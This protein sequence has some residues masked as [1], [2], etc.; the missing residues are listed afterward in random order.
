MPDHKDWASIDD[1]YPRLL[2]VAYRELK[3]RS[4]LGQRSGP[5]PGGMEPKD[6]V[7]DAI[8]KTISGQRVWKPSE[9][10]LFRHLI[11]V[12]RSDINH[13]ADSS[14]NVMTRREDEMSALAPDS[15]EDPE[16]IAIRELDKQRYFLFLERK[17]LALRRLAELIL[18][19]SVTETISLAQ[20]LSLS[21]RDVDSLKRAL[22]RTTIEYRKKMEGNW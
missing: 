20:R 5:S 22:Q 6:V 12:I 17:R 11:G 13:L 1:L 2:L 21:A 18:N 16:T 10:S 8:V 15:R 3:R 19:D 9:I 4:W 7:Q 14:E